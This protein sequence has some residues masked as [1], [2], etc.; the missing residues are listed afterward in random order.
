MYGLQDFVTVNP[1]VFFISI[2][3]LLNG[4]ATSTKMNFSIYPKGWAPYL[5]YSLVFMWLAPHYNY[6]Q[7]YVEL[8]D[9]GVSYIDPQDDLDNGQNR[10]TLIYTDYFQNPGF[11]HD[12][13]IDINAFGG[14]QVDRVEVF[15]ILPGDEFKSLSQ[16]AFGNCVDCV[17]G[18][19][20]N[21]QW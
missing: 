7:S 8:T 9:C 4:N 12:Y 19:C 18:F 1:D 10:D 15:A 3:T 5:A 13:W 6:A 14:Q 16:I 2:A 20:F 17:D 21:P 11:V